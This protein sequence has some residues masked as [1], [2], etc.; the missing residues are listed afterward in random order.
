M[1]FFSRQRRRQN[2]SYC[3]QPVHRR[4]RETKV[5]ETIGVVMDI[6]EGVL[7]TCQPPAF[8]VDL[9]ASNQ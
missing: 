1:I 2:D 9:V 7:A 8:V 6:G 5:V 3:V 4:H